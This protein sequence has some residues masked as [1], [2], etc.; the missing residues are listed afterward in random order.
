MVAANLI[1]LG[2]APGNYPKYDHE[3]HA[4]FPYPPRC[5]GERLMR[6]MGMMKHEYIP[7]T[8]RNL[9]DYYPGTLAK[10]AKFPIGVARKA[11][12]AL[13]E[14]HFLIGSNVLI[15]GKRLSRAFGYETRD[16][17]TWHCEK[18][19][20][21][22]IVPHTSGINQW[23]NDPDNRARGEEFLQSVGQQARDGELTFFVNPGAQK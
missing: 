6:L 7:L 4:L 3:K 20:N 15:V 9:L 22:A 23:W 2:E 8:R 12:I 21:F 16:I 19:Y 11:V 5:S 1:I 14:S 18:A 17:L 10:G 13:H